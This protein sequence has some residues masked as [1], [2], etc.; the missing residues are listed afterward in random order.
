[1]STSPWIGHKA[2]RVS[3]LPSAASPGGSNEN[4]PFADFIA[5][6]LKAE[7][8]R[9]TAL[10]TRGGNLV[11]S[12]GALVAVLAGLG[13]LGRATGG[14]LP[15]SAGP[16]LVMALIGFFAAALFGIAAQWNRSYAVV[17]VDGLRHMVDALWSDDSGTSMQRVSANCL[18]TIETLRKGS[19]AKE[20]LLRWGYACQ[21]G[22]TAFLGPVVFIL[23]AAR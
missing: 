18:G 4:K 17:T 10:D 16:L 2:D 19:S 7:R 8:D 5:S 23:I 12:S 3:D 9:K 14:S 13:T 21:I 20:V 15:T 22:A 6:E 11:T 1:M